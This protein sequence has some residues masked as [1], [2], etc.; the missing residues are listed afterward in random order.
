MSKKLK[1]K[2]TAL[3][4]LGVLGLILAGPGSAAAFGFKPGA[5]TLAPEQIAAHQTERFTKQANLIGATLEEVKNAWA[6]GKSLKDL[7]LSKGI[8]EEQLRLKMQA[9]REA[10]VRARLQ[11]LVDKGVITQAQADRRLETM[12]NQKAK[13]ER[14]GSPRK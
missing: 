5:A 9:E 2:T 6:E 14:G 11:V 8:T 3:A 10:N 13:G 7:A 4:V 1:K 12:K